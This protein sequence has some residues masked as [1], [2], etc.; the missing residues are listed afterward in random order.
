MHKITSQLLG[1]NLYY[2]VIEPAGLQVW[3]MPKR[4]YKKNYATFATKYGSVDRE[5]IVPGTQAPLRVPDGIA[6]FLE[7]KLF[8]E[9]DGNVFDHFA[10]LGAACNAYTNYEATTYLFSCTENF[11]PCLETLLDF[12][13]NPFFTPENVAKE[14]GII[15]QELRMYEDSPRWRVSS[16]LMKAIF[17]HH[18][19]RVDIGGTVASIQEIDAELLQKCY[20]TFYHPSNMVLFATGDLDPDQVLATVQRDLS[21]RGYEPQAPIKRL[22][23][24]EPGSCY[25]SRIEEKMVVSQPILKLGF[26]DGAPGADPT[27]NL[28]REIVTGI[29]LEMLFGKSSQLYATLYEQGLIDQRFSAHYMNGATFALSVLGGETR[30]PE[31]LIELVT[32]GIAAAQ[33]SDGLDIKD[34]ARV[35]NKTTG[36]LLHLLNRLDEVAYLFNDYHF[37]GTSLFVYPEVLASVTL[38]EV[39]DRLVEHLVPENMAVSIIWP[40]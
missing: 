21:P 33:T 25:Q 23:P 7:H 30:D 6:H 39:H 1:E 22:F 9:P 27:A 24:S 31:R 16:N 38:K 3:V 5:F 19:A 11:Y 40:E 35:R 2:D 36:E 15:E 12:V 17:H 29:L 37:R 34:F 14:K 13:Q 18:P 32:G 20:R 28:R 8:E 10:E 4:G 26:K